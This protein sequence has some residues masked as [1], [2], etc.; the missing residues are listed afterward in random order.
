MSKNAKV[1]E[2]V[3]EAGMLDM[4]KDAVLFQGSFSFMFYVWSQT[5]PVYNRA[6][7]R[8]ILKRLKFR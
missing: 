6:C 4:I 5:P 3:V 2:V 7:D 8:R 1:V